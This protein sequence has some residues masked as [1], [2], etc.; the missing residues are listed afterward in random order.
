MVKDFAGGTV[1]LQGTEYRE[2]P[3]ASC[4]VRTIWVQFPYQVHGILMSVILQSPW[5]IARGP[6]HGS[7]S[8][9]VGIRPRSVISRL[10]AREMREEK[11]EEEKER[12]VSISS[13][14]RLGSLS[15]TIYHQAESY[16][17]SYDLVMSPPL[18]AGKGS[19]QLIKVVTILIL[20]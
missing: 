5:F 4:L 9:I 17:G 18:I 6:R 16:Q 11:K 7:T 10:M 3:F 8:D 15:G 1:N 20:D 2:T 12:F 14:D 13:P 19:L